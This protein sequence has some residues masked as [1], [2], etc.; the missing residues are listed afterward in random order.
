MPNDRTRKPSTQLRVE[1]LEDRT[2]PTTFGANR[3]LSLA[4]GDVIPGGTAYEYVTGSGPGNR[5]S[6][7]CSTRTEF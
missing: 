4:V 5:A 3:G 1:V 6:L 7:K 2:V